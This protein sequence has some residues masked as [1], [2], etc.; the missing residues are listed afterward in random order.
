MVSVFEV[1]DADPPLLYQKKVETKTLFEQAL[2]LY[3][4]KAFPESAEC[5][6]A[7]LQE[8]PSDQVAQ[9]YLQRVIESL[10]I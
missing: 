8:N 4:L 10:S 2:T 7:C 3:H 6:E 1:F 9:I 5:F